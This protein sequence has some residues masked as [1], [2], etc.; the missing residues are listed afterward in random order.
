MLPQ[1]LVDI[2]VDMVGDTDI[3]TLKA[4]ALASASLCSASQ[5]ILFRSLT[6][7]SLPNPS[8][9]VAASTLLT[10]SPHIGKYITNV[11]IGL[12]SSGTT[13]AEI[14]AIS[15]VV[16]K[17]TK[18]RRCIITGEGAGRDWDAL[19][20]T[21][22]SDLLDFVSQQT[23]ESLSVCLVKQ[24]SPAALICF[25]SSAPTLSFSS[26]SMRDSIHTSSFVHPP[27]V[28]D[29]VLDEY[30]QDISDKLSLPEYAA[31]TADLR[32]I[33]VRYGPSTLIVHH[34]AHTLQHIRIGAAVSKFI[35][36]PSQPSVFRLRSL[37]PL[38]SLLSFDI[39]VKFDERI[40]EWVSDTITAILDSKKIPKCCNLEEVAITYLPE[41]YWT[42]PGDSYAAFLT[43][44]DGWISAFTPCP[45]LQWRIRFVGTEREKHFALLTVFISDHMPR[46]HSL[47]RLVFDTYEPDWNGGF[48]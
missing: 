19:G 10:K 23:L 45:R 24:I 22:C 25:A 29:L 20:S 47:D 40:A 4:C 2:M 6:L 33:S 16:A 37:P 39:Q 12:P 44:L 42:L 35:L 1:E 11:K 36:G 34:T 14:E 5:P 21:L 30:T 18:V 8:N 3:V 31:Y 32:R 15:R 28:N 46:L 38:P 9:Y 27:S 26:V 43:A 48:V 41:W 17:L 13:P 7:K